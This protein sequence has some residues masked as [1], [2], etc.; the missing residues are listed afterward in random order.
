M[1][2]ANNS[3]RALSEA[4]RYFSDLDVATEFVARLR[5]PDGP[6]C[7]NCGSRDYSY[8][9]TRRLW[10]CK[11][12]QRQFSVKVGTIFENSP[13]GLDKWL[14]AIWMLANS[15]DV[16]SSYEIHH[17]I[18]VTQKTAWSMMHRISL[19]MQTKTFERVSGQVE[20]EGGCPGDEAR[21]LHAGNREE[22]VKGGGSVGEIAIKGSTRTL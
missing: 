16:I 4:I 18:G 6:I 22:K 5:W 14:A 9:R 12:C 8:L 21:N 15:K 19:A 11:V 17:T 3:P 20:I 13:I 10:K 7:P 2:N 1:K